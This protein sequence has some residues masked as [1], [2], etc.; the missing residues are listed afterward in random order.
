MS[1]RPSS[2]GQLVGVRFKE[3]MREPEAATLQLPP[4]SPS[5]RIAIWAS[6]LG[7]LFLGIFPSA[8]L[9]FASVSAAALR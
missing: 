1:D 6:A 2:L 5:L 4:P 3:Y 7:T 9:G 8:V